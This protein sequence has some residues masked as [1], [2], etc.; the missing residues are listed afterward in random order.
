MCNLPTIVGSNHKG[1][2]LKLKV[3]GIPFET[4]LKLELVIH[5][6]DGKVLHTGCLRFFPNGIF[7]LKPQ[8]TSF[9]CGIFEAATVGDDSTATDQVSYAMVQLTTFG[10]IGHQLDVVDDDFD[11]EAQALLTLLNLWNVDHHPD[12]TKAC[13]FRIKVAFD[14]DHKDNEQFWASMEE[15]KTENLPNIRKPLHAYCHKNGRPAT[16]LGMIPS[17]ETIRNAHDSLVKYRF[18]KSFSHPYEY[19]VIMANGTFLEHQRELQLITVMQRSLHQMTVYDYEGTIVV[20]IALNEELDVDDR[21][22]VTPGSNVTI[23]WKRQ[24]ALVSGSETVRGVIYDYWFAGIPEKYTVVVVNPESLRYIEDLAQKVAAPDRKFYE[25]KIIFDVNEIPVRRR[26]DA[27]NK[28]ISDNFSS[29]HPAIMARS[30]ASLVRCDLTDCFQPDH[31]MRE[32]MIKRAFDKVL[33]SSNLNPDQRNAFNLIRSAPGGIL[34]IEGCPGGGKTWLLVMIAIA[35]RQLGIYVLF[36]TPT[37]AAADAIMKTSKMVAKATGLELKI[38]R[39]YS[40]PHETEAFFNEAKQK[41]VLDKGLDL[42]KISKNDNMRT[43]VMLKTITALGKKYASKRYA[44]TEDSLERAVVDKAKAKQKDVHFPMTA[45]NHVLVHK[46]LGTTLPPDFSDKSPDE[47]FPVRVYELINLFLDLMERTPK[48]EEW[49]EGLETICTKAFK[50][51]QEDIVRECGCI[52]TTTNNV[53]G[54]PIANGVGALPKYA[55]IVA[56]IDE[57]NRDLEQDTAIVLTKLKQSEKLQGVVLAGDAKQPPPLVLT[58][59]ETPAYNEM[60]AQIAISLPSRIVNAGHPQAT[61]K[62]NGRAHPELNEWPNKNNYYGMLTDT[63]VVKALPLNKNYEEAIRMLVKQP[64][65]KISVRLVVLSVPDSNCFT[66]AGSTS[67]VNYANVR[68]VVSLVAANYRAGGYSAEDILIM[69]PW[70][71][72][73]EAL[74]SNLLQLALNGAVPYEHIPEVKTVHGMQ[75]GQAKC[76]IFDGT[77]SHADRTGDVGHIRNEELFNVATTRAREAA[78]ILLPHGLASGELAA[79]FSRRIGGPP[80]GDRLHGIAPIAYIHDMNTKA[81]VVYILDEPLAL[82]EGI[83]KY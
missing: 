20:A 8:I 45:A 29:W 44:L 61:L 13:K 80:G 83:G 76:I 65:P 78:I 9:E 16:V 64:D 57:S 56:L 26:I 23:N 18:K 72:Q 67:K 6:Q 1:T 4:S 2:E 24:G 54:T 15:L 22:R 35:L 47:V 17:R 32:Q 41:G 69:S 49:T 11:T 37:H 66:P 33:N 77:V 51:A 75:G 5:G 3:E 68:T 38:K 10:G 14:P 43:V 60:S 81:N 46:E 74:S 55:G 21:Y 48:V 27:V 28:L 30:S 40:S 70:A 31:P 25:A 73:A 52:A 82:P 59:N 71:K 19:G 53:A 63:E 50:R 62:Y 42:A 7:T 79:K 12:R 34:D 39:A 58:D 36:A